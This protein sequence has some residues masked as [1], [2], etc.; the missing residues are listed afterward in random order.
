MLVH[1]D[2]D[3]MA[4]D[5]VIADELD[6]MRRNEA[7]KNTTNFGIGCPQSSTRINKRKTEKISLLRLLIR[8]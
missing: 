7:I 8:D 3:G 2:V 5:A 6:C 1:G 4:G